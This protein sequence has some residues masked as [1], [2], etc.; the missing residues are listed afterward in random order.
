MASDVTSTVLVA[1]LDGYQSPI[2]IVASAV[3][4]HPSSIFIMT[5]IAAVELLSES[6]PR[7][8]HSIAVL[9]DTLYIL[10]GEIQPR[11]PATPFLHSYSFKGTF[12]SASCREL[13]VDNLLQ[14]LETEDAP[15]IRVGAASVV[16][17]GKIY[18][19]GGRGGKA[20]T[21]LDEQG[22]FWIY[23]GQSWS[24]TPVPTGDIP[25]PRSYHSLAAMNVLCNYPLYAD[26]RAR[27]ICTPGVL[28]RDDCQLYTSIPL[29]RIYGH[30]SPLRHPS[31]AVGLLS[32][33]WMDTFSALA[34][35]MALN[36]VVK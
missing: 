10:G 4:C 23:D 28:R 5:P 26:I 22:K 14:A 20:M 12:S 9:G 19:W 15:P 34:G 30:N 1:F 21:P 29:Q 31:L 36:S 33:R 35:S 24:Q 16:V 17:E 18:V 27:F 32:S 7:S 2:L 11:E 13:T 25:Q 6:L 8:S 3:H